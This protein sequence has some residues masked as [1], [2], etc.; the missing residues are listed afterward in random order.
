MISSI[1]P[2]IKN[3]PANNSLNLKSNNSITVNRSAL[4][5]IHNTDQVRFGHLNLYKPEKEG[6]LSKIGNSVKKLWHWVLD[7]FRPTSSDAIGKRINN[8][9]IQIKA[10]SEDKQLMMAG[11]NVAK[12]FIEKSEGKVVTQQAIDE[13]LSIAINLYK[14]LVAKGNEVLRLFERADQKHGIT[15]EAK[16]EQQKV[17]KQFGVLQTY[18]DDPKKLESEIEVKVLAQHKKVTDSHDRIAE[19]FMQHQQLSPHFVSDK[20]A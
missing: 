11:E 2:F 7:F 6:F 8:L 15:A 19:M 17:I 10:D 13:Q 3:Q 12:L 4:N 18:V 16:E 1:A 20:Q 5:S 14:P 9:I